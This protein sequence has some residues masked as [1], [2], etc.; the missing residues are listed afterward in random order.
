MGKSLIDPKDEG[1]KELCAK[2]EIIG[3][4]NKTRVIKNLSIIDINK[5]D[6]I[7]IY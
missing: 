4:K 1:G 3:T 7:N 5:H 6:K 2:T